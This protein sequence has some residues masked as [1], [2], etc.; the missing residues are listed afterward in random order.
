MLEEYYKE[1]SKGMNAN[2]NTGKQ[3]KKGKVE[4]SKERCQEWEE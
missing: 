2:D 1:E 4:E 3:E